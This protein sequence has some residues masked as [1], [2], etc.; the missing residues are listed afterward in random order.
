MAA[1]VRYPLTDLWSGLQYM[2]SFEILGLEILLLLVQLV[3]IGKNLMLPFVLSSVNRRRKGFLGG[4]SAGGGSSVW[5]TVSHHNLSPCSAY[6]CW[7]FQ[8]HLDVENLS[9]L[10]STEF[11]FPQLSRYLAVRLSQQ[12]CTVYAVVWVRRFA[13]ICLLLEPAMP[14]CNA[15]LSDQFQ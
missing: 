5:A 9:S 15:V 10:N 2:D 1:V 7:T 11:S 6:L 4:W 13:L 8:R 3:S 14:S 12:E